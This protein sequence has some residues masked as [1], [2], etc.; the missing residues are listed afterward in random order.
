MLSEVVWREF[1]VAEVEAA[2]V[3]YARGEGRFG[4]TSAQV[5]GAR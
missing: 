1:G 5:R 2:V 3:D 4:R